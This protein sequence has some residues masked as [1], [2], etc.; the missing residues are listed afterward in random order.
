M[1]AEITGI[2]W[3]TA[4]S[5]GCAKER[6]SF[7]MSHEKLP[8]LSAQALFKGPYS[9]FRRMDDDNLNHWMAGTSWRNRKYLV[10]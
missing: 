8:P 7:S 5:A 6:T 3:I 9:T 2:G 1:V 10:R 4:N